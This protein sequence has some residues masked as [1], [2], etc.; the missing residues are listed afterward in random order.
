MDARPERPDALTYRNGRDA[1]GGRIKLHAIDAHNH[2]RVRR[3]LDLLY[4]VFHI[5]IVDDAGMADRLRPSLS[6]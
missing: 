6:G 1:G 2:T 5:R 4:H 3:G